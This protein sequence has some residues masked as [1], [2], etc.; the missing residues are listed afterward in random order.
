MKFSETEGTD[1]TNSSNKTLFLVLLVLMFSMTTAVAADLNLYSQKDQVVAITDL[2]TD[3]NV[4]FTG[5]MQNGILE[6]YEHEV[7]SAFDLKS[8]SDGTGGKSNSDGTGGK[9]NSDGTGGTNSNSDGTGTPN[10]LLT[11][12]FECHDGQL[13]AVGLVDTDNGTQTFTFDAVYLNGEPMDCTGN[14]AEDS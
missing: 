14:D 8:N 5:L 3:E 13:Q 6:A 12:L 9:S 10:S 7:T 2:G 11:V 4:F 1:I